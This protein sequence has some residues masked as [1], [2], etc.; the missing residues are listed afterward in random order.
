MWI[1]AGLRDSRKTGAIYL[2]LTQSTATTDDFFGARIISNPSE[3]VSPKFKLCP[4]FDC[5]KL[6]LTVIIG[7]GLAGSQLSKREKP[8][9][10]CLKFLR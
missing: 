3:S 10:S 5:W 8:L 7:T 4:I 6:V 9:H 1:S 2:L